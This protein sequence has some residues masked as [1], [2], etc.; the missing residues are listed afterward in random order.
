MLPK[1]DGEING[2][3]KNDASQGVITAMSD[4]IALTSCGRK[5]SWWMLNPCLSDRLL[6][7]ARTTTELGTL[8]S[9]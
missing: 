4:V 8:H 2:H 9:Q 1:C 7:I 5:A 6:K 3:Q